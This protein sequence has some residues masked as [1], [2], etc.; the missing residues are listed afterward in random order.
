MSVDRDAILARHAQELADYDAQMRRNIQAD[1]EHRQWR[2]TFRIRAA[3]MF[4][5]PCAEVTQAQWDAA[6]ERTVQDTM[7]RAAR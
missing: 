6:Y 3:S 2:S 5:V 1:V 4:G 7:P